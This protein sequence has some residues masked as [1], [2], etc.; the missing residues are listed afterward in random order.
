MSL[1]CSNFAGNW[2]DLLTDKDK[3]QSPRKSCPHMV[4]GKGVWPD[5]EAVT[6]WRD[7]HRV[8][9]WAR[10]GCGFAAQGTSWATAAA[11]AASL[12]LDWLLHR[13]QCRWGVV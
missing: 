11:S 12:C 1:P 8:R 9:R 2:Q 13:R 7:I 5:E 3:P 10:A 4:R 6:L